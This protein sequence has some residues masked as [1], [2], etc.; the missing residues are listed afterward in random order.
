MRKIE[1]HTPLSEKEIRR[2]SVGDHVFIS[3]TVITA[4]DA[5]HKRMMKYMA[6]KKE[7]PFS[8]EGSALYHCGP[9]VRKVKGEWRVLAAGPTTSMRMEP[10]E[11]EVIENLR[12]R[13][14]IGKGGMG[15]KTRD[16]MNRCGAVYGVFT[17][18]A[19]VLAAKHIKRVVRVEWLDLGMPEAAWVFEVERFG[20]LVVGMDS[21]GRSLYEEVRIESLRRLNCILEALTSE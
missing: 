16:A 5:A 4:R 10:F 20:P 15:E 14:V 18:G 8:F 13:L 9:L 12:V 7:L 11:A 1:L 17:G 6:E 19:A 3:G 2:L 21:H